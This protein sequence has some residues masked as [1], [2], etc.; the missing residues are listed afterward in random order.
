MAVRSNEAMTPDAL[1]ATFHEQIRLADRDAEVGLVV[2]HDGL[3]HRVYPP[4]PA[5]PGAMIESPEGLG[6]D[7]DGA[8]ARQREFF[9][10]REQRV[11]WKTYSYDEPT[12]LGGR[13]TAAGFVAE[14][15]EALI[16][17]E[18][19]ALAAK[20][21][22]L[23]EGVRLRPI[24]TADLPGVAAFQDVIWGAGSAWVTESHF[25]ELQAAPDLMHGC[26]VERE[27]D[28][29]VLTAS[30]L[31]LTPDTE[32]C[33]LWGG[34]TLEAYRRQGLYRASVAYRARLALELG[35]RLVRV[36]ASVNS[37][38]VLRRL[39]LHQVATTTPYILDPRAG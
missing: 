10:R 34:S 14:D 9:A 20:E 8:I 30:W 35:S 31:R 18:L 16:L 19:D 29:L 39:G 2:E 36:D 25:A 7:P 38:P 5:V 33:G 6:D 17:G 13:L 28:G 1:L 12:D 4:D 3:V 27:A 26:L 24:T 15:E 21:I 37:R 32:F 22:S 11:E 23:P